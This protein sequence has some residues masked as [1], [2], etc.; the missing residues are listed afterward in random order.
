[1]MI[2]RRRDVVLALGAAVLLSAGRLSPVAAQEAGIAVGSTVPSAS[3]VLLDGTAVDLR[4]FTGKKPVVFEFWATWCP[5]CKQLEPRM[6]AARKAH[7]DQVAFVSVGVADNQTPEKQA[8]YVEKAG[9]GGTFVFDRDGAAV[10]AFKAPHT[11][12]LV[13]VDAK[14]KVVYTG[15]GGD[16]DVE[17]AIAKVG[18]H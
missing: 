2:V 16:Q 13:V 17:A 1:M 6:A 3:V 5:L 12:F 4:T 8:S 10:K 9:L 14:G 7:G 15:V 11:S 18:M